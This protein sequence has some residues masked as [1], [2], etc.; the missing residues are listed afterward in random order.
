MN[1][2]NELLIDGWEICY[3]KEN[4]EYNKEKLLIPIVVISES[5]SGKSFLLGYLILIY[6]WD[7]VK[8]QKE[9]LL[10]IYSMIK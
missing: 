5:N 2:L 9:F 3:S 7:L 1:L 10:N 8:K 4:Y 6:L